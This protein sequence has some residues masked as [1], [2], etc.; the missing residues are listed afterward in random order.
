[1]TAADLD[2]LQRR[3]AGSSSAAVSSGRRA[4]IEARLNSAGVRPP[5]TTY[6]ISS[7]LTGAARAAA[8]EM[9]DLLEER[10]GLSEARCAGA[11]HVSYIVGGARETDA[12]AARL[13]AVAS[14]IA[15]VDIEIDGLGIFDGLGP[16]LFLR[17]RRTERLRQDHALVLEAAR[18]GFSTIWPYYL[19][20]AWTPHV[21]LALRDL[22]PGD[23]PAIRADLDR[24]PTRLP[25]RLERLDLV[26]V[27]FPRHVYV[28]RFRLAP[29]PGCAAP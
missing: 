11:P 28:G 6:G 13:A 2:R 18:D 24:R 29:P 25:A 26:H 20:D 21:T 15:P 9:W 19:A 27:V 16:A 14:R 3:R 1:M 7:D 23:L 12:L 8:I 22:A 4:A 17:V 10:Y 5:D